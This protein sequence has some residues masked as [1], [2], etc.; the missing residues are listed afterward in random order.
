MCVN[1]KRVLFPLLLNCR[2]G[3]SVTHLKYKQYPKNCEQAGNK[4][5]TQKA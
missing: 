4:P 1:N 3:Y 2:V 5:D